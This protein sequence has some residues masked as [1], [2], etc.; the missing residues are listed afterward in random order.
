MELKTEPRLAIP[1]RSRDVVSR[2][3]ALLSEGRAL[4]AENGRAPEARTNA[5]E[6]S[7]LSALMENMAFAGSFGGQGG[8]TDTAA[9][10]YT[11]SNAN[12]Y[13]TVSLNR[14]LLSYSYM[15]QGLLRTAVDQPVEDAFRGGI[16]FKSDQL[17]PDELKLLNREFKRKRRKKRVGRSG[18]P[19]LGVEDTPLVR[20]NEQVGYDF[21]NSDLDACKNVARWARLYGGAG[22]IVNTDQ[23]FRKDLSVDA[24]REDSPLSFIAADRWELT[25]TAA[26]LFDPRVERPFNYYGLPLNRTRVVTM[27]G[28]EAPAFIRLRL[29]GWGMSFLERCLR[30]VSAF[31]KF[32]RVM[33]ELLDEAK[34][35]IFKIKGF[36]A[37]LISAEGTQR[38][39]RRVMLANQQKNFQTA[40]SMD[41]ED[42]YM[43]KTLG[44]I[45]SGLAAVWEQLRL[46][47]CAYV[48]IPM[49]KL[50]GTSAS[51][52]SSG[53]DSM[54][55]YN[56][57]VGNMRENVE[58]VVITAGELRC[59]NLFGT[60]PDDLEVEWTPLSVLDGV[61][62]EAV[63][64]SRQNRII[65]RYEKGLTTDK[66]A[67]QEM[68]NEELIFCEP[69]EVERGIREAEPPLSENPDEVQAGRDHEAGMAEAANKAKAKQA[70]S[71]QIGRK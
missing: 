63:K 32:E 9:L 37:Q 40:L 6:G 48:R 47:L 66:E 23:D 8:V 59:Q 11:L 46:N 67:S 39:Q 28:D 35:D 58:P 55:N 60:I 7:G 12:S 33:F 43:Q 45:F 29:Q 56:A 42:D 49:T 64:T 51:G 25:L 13:A 4:L 16:R 24:I 14:N 20:I 41:M 71:R 19:Q 52:F 54:D 53:K 44:E 50:F 68:R 2:A 69:T 27:M 21:S 15:S 31:I 34:I 3:T 61:E 38:I 70:T 65:Q 26:N 18:L 30:P 17:D 10:P 36:N 22:M 57:D 62:T 5:A 1:T